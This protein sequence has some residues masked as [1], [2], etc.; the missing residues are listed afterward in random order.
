MVL[1]IE[2]NVCCYRDISWGT[3]QGTKSHKIISKRKKIWKTL[4]IIASLFRF[5]M[6][7]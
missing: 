2:I 1:L 5:T 4:P 7:N 6:H 3:F